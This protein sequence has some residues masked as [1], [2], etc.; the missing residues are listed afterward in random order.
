MRY[1]PPWGFD[2]Y[3]HRGFLRHDLHDR[4]RDHKFFIA[5]NVGHGDAS[6]IRDAAEAISPEWVGHDVT[7]EGRSQ[8]QLA[9][10]TRRF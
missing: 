9:P 3:R 6:G 2:L 5:A 4:S 7:K 8:T 1:A 10:A